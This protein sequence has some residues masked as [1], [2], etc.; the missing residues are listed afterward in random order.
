M[1]RSGGT[2]II[3]K[4]YAR[5][6]SEDVLNFR[7]NTVL[8]FGDSWDIIGAAVLINPGSAKPIGKVHQDELM[9]LEAL[10]SKSDCWDL[11]SA[12]PT[13]NQLEKIFNGWYLGTEKPLN[14]VILLYNL[15]NLRDKDL[16]QA[17]ELQKSCGSPLLFTTDADIEAMKAIDHIYLGWGNAGKGPL[18]EYAQRIFEAVKTRLAY[19]INPDFDRNAFYHPGYVNRSYRHNPTTKRILTEFNT[20]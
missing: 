14:G 15:F 1:R 2:I 17:I 18:H 9:H 20:L 19:Y 8:Q 16:G 7:Q 5:F 10:T 3:M 6:F 13:M 4:V 12:D 11:F